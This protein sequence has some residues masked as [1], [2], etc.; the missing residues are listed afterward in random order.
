MGLRKTYAFNV[1]PSTTIQELK[2][3][4]HKRADDLDMATI[5]LSFNGKMLDEDDKALTHYNVEEDSVLVL[6]NLLGDAS[7]TDSLE[8]KFVDVSESEGLKRVEWSTTGKKWRQVQ[9]GMCLEG[10][11]IKSK[12]EAHDQM[13]IIPIGYGTFDVL[14]DSDTNSKCPMCKEYV[15]PIICSFNNCWWKYKGK[16]KEKDDDR[17]PPQ[18]CNGDWKQADDACHYF[19]EQTS[20]M[21]IWRQ[22]I[23]EVIKDKP[24]Q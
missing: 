22:L 11:C 19:D 13:V 3:R 12:C 21:V 23:F 10:K 14:R 18:E 4:L 20:E 1:Q 16:R 24:Q 7:D 15:E 5:G 9:H 17:N 2:T 8:V 6:S